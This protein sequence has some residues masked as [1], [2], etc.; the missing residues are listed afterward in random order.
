M[1]GEKHYKLF[2]T[3]ILAYSIEDALLLIER[4]I[5]ERGRLL[6]G[7]VNAA[8]LVNMRRSRVLRESMEKCD[9]IFADGMSVVWALRLLGRRLPG[10]VPGIDLMDQ[11]LQRGQ[12][13]GW[14]VYLF[15]ATEEVSKEVERRIETEYSG[16]VVAGRRNGYY[17]ADQE[18][19]VVEQIRSCKPDVLFVAMSPP[20]KELFLAKWRDRLEVPVC[21]GVGGAFDVMAGKVKRAPDLW[22]QLGMEWLYRIVQEPRRMWRRYLVTNTLFGCMLLREIVRRILVRD[23]HEAR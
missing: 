15:G 3:P 20:K 16:L 17:E 13:H 5:V 21:H 8:K 1:P 11:I 6:I 22:Q 9:V 10:R 19:Q 4:T 18:E 7:V 2:G 14:R 12:A 23:S